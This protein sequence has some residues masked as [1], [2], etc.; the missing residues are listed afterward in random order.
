MTQLNKYICDGTVFTQEAFDK[1][2][3]GDESANDPKG[4]EIELDKGEDMIAADVAEK[5]AEL[6]GHDKGVAF[7][8]ALYDLNKMEGGF[9]CLTLG[10]EFDNEA[11]YTGT[12][13]NS[14]KAVLNDIDPIVVDFGEGME[15]TITWGAEVFASAKGLAASALTMAAAMVIAQH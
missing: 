14:K 10:M 1:T 13:F 2:M 4:L 9:C 8:R 3:D 5:I 12:M 6:K 15:L 11:D 7:C